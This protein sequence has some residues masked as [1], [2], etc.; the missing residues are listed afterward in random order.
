MLDHTWPDQCATAL[1]VGPDA[2]WTASVDSRSMPV[3]DSKCNWIVS[4]V[5]FVAKRHVAITL[6]YSN[7]CSCYAVCR[8]VRPS[9]RLSDLCPPGKY[10]AKSRKR[11]KIRCTFV[12]FPDSK[13]VTLNDIERHYRHFV[14]FF[15]E[16]SRFRS[17]L[18]LYPYCLQP[19]VAQEL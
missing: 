13:S 10:F 14:L 9:V 18:K 3:T 7:L 16:S 17:W 1:V 11:C 4:D 8:S 2:L 6:A 12:W 5:E 15:A 19:N